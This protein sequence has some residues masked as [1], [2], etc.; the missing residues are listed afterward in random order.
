MRILS[1]SVSAEEY[2]LARRVKF[3]NILILLLSSIIF[4]QCA[5]IIYRVVGLYRLDAPGPVTARCSKGPDLWNE[6]PSPRPG[7][8][9]YQVVLERNL[10]R[11]TGKALPGKEGGLPE[12]ADGA[13]FLTSKCLL[14][15]TVVE[16]LQYGYAI[17]EDQ[18]R[19]KQI[20]YRVGDNVAGA[21]LVRITRDKAFFSIN[22][23][24]GVL[25]RTDA[26]EESI[27][28][29]RDVGGASVPAPVSPGLVQVSRDDVRASLR[30][31]GNLMSQGQLSPY[32]QAGRIAGFQLSNVKAGGVYQ[33]LG[34]VNGDIIKEINSRSMQRADNINEIYSSLRSGS[35]LT[36]Q[37][38]RQGELE[39]LQYNF[40]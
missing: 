11:L 30:D 7:L 36:L 10:F 15:G 18:S 40:H 26:T 14:K 33:K 39:I 28:P 3:R 21:T 37:V 27:L 13:S 19:Q 31:M 5:D 20:L 23:K 8:E 35:R 12:N 38:N 4:C 6:K 29:D 16:G 22:G 34:L 25:K 24:E 9:F 1:L 17:I 2:C 32:Y